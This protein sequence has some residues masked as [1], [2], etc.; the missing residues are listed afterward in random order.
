MSEKFRA[1]DN[2]LPNF[3]PRKDYC[4]KVFRADPRSGQDNL[5]VHLLRDGRVELSTD[6]L[7]TSSVLTV[8]E[9]KRVVAF[10]REH[11]KGS[12]DADVLGALHNLGYE[13]REARR[14]L[15]ECT[16][17]SFDDKLRSALSLAPKPSQHRPAN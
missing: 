7:A 5:V 9:F 13:P 8:A 4:P 16:G 11:L 6:N 1:N 3:L 17:D 12:F 15:A 2:D 14:M 10:V